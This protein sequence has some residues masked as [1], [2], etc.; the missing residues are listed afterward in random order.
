[1]GTPANAQGIVEE[2]E[3]LLDDGEDDENDSEL[4]DP[5]IGTRWYKNYLN[6]FV[7]PTKDD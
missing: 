1:M 3:T 2:L 6:G 4:R 5:K 7:Y